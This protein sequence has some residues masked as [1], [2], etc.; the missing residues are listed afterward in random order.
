MTEMQNLGAV[1]P[2]TEVPEGVGKEPNS[3]RITQPPRGKQAVAARKRR[4]RISSEL[5]GTFRARLAREYQ[6]L[7]PDSPRIKPTLPRLKL[8]GQPEE[9]A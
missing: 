5:W 9:A 3:F 8:L 7:P 4:R 2:A 1:P 6:G